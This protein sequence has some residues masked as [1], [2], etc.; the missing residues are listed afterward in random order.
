MLNKLFG[1]FRGWDGGAYIESFGGVA[2]TKWC[3]SH[4]ECTREQTGDV[5]HGALP[6]PIGVQLI[7]PVGGP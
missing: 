7:T 2:P 3:Q 4:R 1:L 6:V 5:C